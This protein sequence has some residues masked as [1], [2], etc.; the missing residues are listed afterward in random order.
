MIQYSTAIVLCIIWI[1]LVI[2][3][4]ISLASSELSI[5]EVTKQPAKIIISWFIA[6]SI[7]AIFWSILITFGVLDGLYR[8]FRR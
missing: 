2:G 5:Q 3:V 7:V 6:Q 4:M 1:Y 8:T